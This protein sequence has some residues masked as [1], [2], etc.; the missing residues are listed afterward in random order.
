ME[1]VSGKTI[2]MRDIGCEAISELSLEGGVFR[3]QVVKESEFFYTLSDSSNYWGWA[4]KVGLRGSGQYVEIDITHQIVVLREA[5][6]GLELVF[7]LT[8]GGMPGRRYRG[9]NRRGSRRVEDVNVGLGPQHVAMHINKKFVLPQ[10]GNTKDNWITERRTM[11]ARTEWE[12]KALYGVVRVNL[13][14]SVATLPFP[15]NASVKGCRVF[16]E[17]WCRLWWTMVALS[18]R[19]TGAPES[20]SACTSLTW[21]EGVMWVFQTRWGS[22]GCMYLEDQT[23]SLSVLQAPTVVEAKTAATE[24]ATRV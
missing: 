9:N 3:L 22:K 21:G 17:Q 1:D 10:K 5:K 14:H 11:I 15:S 20:I 8:K 23:S 13:H 4:R 2:K 12:E 19:L 7:F 16:R 6:S 24:P 18:M